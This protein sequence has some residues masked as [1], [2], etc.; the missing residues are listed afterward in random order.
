MA[1][2]QTGNSPHYVIIG[3]GVAGNEAAFH[4]RDRDPDSRITIISAGRLLFYNRYELPRMFSV[5][6][7]CDWRNFLVHPVEYY[8]DSAIR[9]LR[10]TCVLQVNPEDRTLS[11]EHKETIAYDKLLVASG[12]S[13]Y[14]PPELGHCRHLLDDFHG[15]RAACKMRERLPK[16][17]KMVLLGG[18]VLG[19]DLA[20]TLVREGYGVTLIPAEQTFWPH[21]V[22]EADRPKFLRALETMGLEVRYGATVETVEEGGSGMSAR[23]VV[24]D[25]GS[26]L[27][28]DVVMPSYGL[29]P[30]A[31]FMRRAGIDMERGLLVDTNLRT[32]DPH[33]W[34]A[35]DVCQIWSADEKAY[36]FYYGWRNVKRMGRIAAFNMT[37]DE[38]VVDG[39]ADA[40]LTVDSDGHIDSP[41]WE[42]D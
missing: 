30:A 28:V 19:L 8:T 42:Y 6:G 32:T 23:R 35:G 38:V 33:I 29:S 25:D 2:T 17:G 27:F 41:Y 12:G 14:L 34:A 24:L 21:M 37:G 10:N 26:E 31:D 4:L 11:L 16:G 18:D 3:N 1:Q 13:A 40:T 7:P 22:A 39:V 15:Y 20:R 36:R 9:A 5:D